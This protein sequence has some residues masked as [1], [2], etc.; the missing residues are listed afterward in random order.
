[1]MRYLR[2]IYARNIYAFWRD[3]YAFLH[4]VDAVIMHTNI[5]NE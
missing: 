3:I 5:N 1:M 4:V 2:D